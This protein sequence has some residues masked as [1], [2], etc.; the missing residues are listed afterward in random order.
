MTNVT[1]IATFKADRAKPSQVVWECPCGCQKYVITEDG[2][3]CAD[4]DR[5][6][7]WGEILTHM[8]IVVSTMDYERGL[9]GGC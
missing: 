3:Q 4:C 7:S 9:R 6:W 5:R 1:S 2:P 8:E